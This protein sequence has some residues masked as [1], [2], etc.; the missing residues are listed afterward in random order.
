MSNPSLQQLRRALSEAGF[1]VYR[2]RGHE[3]HLAERPRENQIMDAG[4]IVTVGTPFIVTF[5]VRAQKSDFPGED[6]TSLL[7]RARILADRCLSRG[8]AENDAR[9]RMLL[10]PGDHATVLDVWYE[11]TFAKSVEHLAD[12]LDEAK[13]ALA[14]EKTAHKVDELGY[15]PRQYAELFS[16]PGP[17]KCAVWGDCFGHFGRFCHPISPGSRVGWWH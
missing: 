9:E 2:T 17:K 13:F 8:Y 12:T 5:T 3:I 16:W 10:D 6:K 1:E 7:H 4:V 14:L 15:L 11:V